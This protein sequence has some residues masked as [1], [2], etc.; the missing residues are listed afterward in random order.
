M[1]ELIPTFFDFS[2]LVQNAIHAADRAKVS[3]LVQQRRI[4]FPGRLIHKPL[5]VKCIQNS[6]TL[7]TGQRPGGNRSLLYTRIRGLRQVPSIITGSGKPE[8]ITS[9]SHSNVLG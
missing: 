8:S 5:G 2:L 4:D 7:F 1:A 9:F 6:L 3:S